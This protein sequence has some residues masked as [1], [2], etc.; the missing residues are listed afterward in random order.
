MIRKSIL[1]KLLLMNFGPKQFVLL[2][3]LVLLAC[4]AAAQSFCDDFDSYA[5]GRL[6]SQSV[7]WHAWP[8]SIGVQDTEVSNLQSHSGDRSMRVHAKGLNAWSDI[9]T[10]FGIIDSGQWSISYRVFVPSNGGGRLASLA[11]FNQSSPSSSIF[12]HLINLNG[13]TT[14]GKLYDVN[15][16]NLSLV[17]QFDFVL[18]QWFEISMD[19]DLDLKKVQY[20]IDSVL[21][22]S[23]D[24]K[25][26]D[27]VLQNQLQAF[28]IW[29]Q[30]ETAGFPADIFVDDF[31]ISNNGQVGIDQE[32]EKQLEIY[33]QPTD[34]ILH[35]KGLPPS[36]TSFD[37]RDV[38]GRTLLKGYH[39][40]GREI[41]HLDLSEFPSGAYFFLTPYSNKLLLKQ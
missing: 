30:N 8:G 1:R 29:S 19:I 33:P 21:L 12:M 9:Y 28:N 6:D 36:G 5:L 3:M 4:G 18:N 24:W 32:L 13:N 40:A 20:Y 39:P 7:F 14:K 15:G 25:S 2:P 22:Y 23:G 35:V 26:G 27:G 41:L 16:T 34:R 10:N 37:V 38:K 11:H 31:C 17:K